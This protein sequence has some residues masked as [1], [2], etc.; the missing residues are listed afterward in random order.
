VTSS[1]EPAPP[2]CRK[3]AKAAPSVVATECARCGLIFAKYRTTRPFCAYVPSEV[4]AILE[5]PADRCVIRLR[6]STG[7]RSTATLIAPAPGLFAGA[8]TPRVIRSMPD[9]AIENFET[10]D[11]SSVATSLG[12]LENRRFASAVLQW[13]QETVPKESE[14]LYSFTPLGFVLCGLFEDGS[15]RVLLSDARRPPAQNSEIFALSAQHELQWRRV[16]K[17]L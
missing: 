11:P 7:G 2:L 1:A 9:C 6:V 4:V 13:L 17:E 10:A 15:R 12:D 3:C 14:W 16:M 5:L 8:E